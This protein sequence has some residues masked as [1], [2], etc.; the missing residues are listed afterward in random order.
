MPSRIRRG[1]Q[2]SLEGFGPSSLLPAWMLVGVV[3]VVG[4]QLAIVGFFDWSDVCVV[5]VM[6]VAVH[7]RDRRL[8]SVVSVVLFTGSFPP[9]SWPTWWFCF[10]PILWMWRNQELK[11]SMIRLGLEAVAVGFAMGWLSTGFVR[12]ALPAWGWVIHAVA[13]VLYSLQV[14]AFAVAIR[15]TRNKPVPVAAVTCTLAAVG[16]ELFAAWCGVAWSVTNFALTVGA[17]PLAQWSRWITP[18]GVSGL[19]YLVNFLLIIEDSGKLVTKWIGPALGL[20]ICVV[21][22]VGGYMIAATVRFEPLSFSV[23]LVQPH[24]KASKNLPWRPWI[25]LDRLTRASLSRDG[26]VDLIVWPETCLSESLSDGERSNVSDIAGRLS[27]QDFAHVLT[28]IYDANCLVGAVLA[29]RGTTLR[30]GLKVANV[31][32]FNCACLISKVGDIA[33]HEKL[34]LV[35]LKEGLPDSLNIDWMRN[36]ILPALEFRQQLSYGRSFATLSFRDRIGIRRSIAASVCYE[37]LFPWLPQYRASMHADAI[38]HLVYDGHT[39][40]HRGMM[41][42]HIIACQYR[43][44]ETRK[45]NLICSTWSGS[46]VIDPSGKIVSMLPGNAGVIRNELANGKGTRLW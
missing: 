46:A 1:D 7:G 42:R 41:Q 36:R 5:F 6:T 38:I 11:L 45:W 3:G 40:E 33:R 28:P 17:T 26:A 18:F 19:L 23:L 32:R 15:V 31:R 22:W 35:P 10:V 29:E 39:A 2:A 21:T 14:A 44:I 8:M 27:V 24:L 37:S 12:T 25:D 9:Y 43:A 13:C 20:G 16:G 34:A 30:F 4:T